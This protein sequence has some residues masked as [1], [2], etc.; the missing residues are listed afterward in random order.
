MHHDKNERKIILGNS[1]EKERP[2]WTFQ[3]KSGRSI[4]WFSIHNTI[5]LP[6]LEHWSKIGSHQ[7]LYKIGSYL[8]VL[9]FPVKKKNIFLHSKI[10]NNRNY[11]FFWS[12]FRVI[13]VR[14]HVSSFGVLF[15][16]SCH[17]RKLIIIIFCN[18]FFLWKR[19]KHY[20]VYDGWALVGQWI[21]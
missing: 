14:L 6:N 2:L 20:K 1:T 12:I 16:F 10:I 5:K 19:N 18:G 9:N 11:Y 17:K 7:K 21:P 4:R 13:E 8:T 15:N 3:A